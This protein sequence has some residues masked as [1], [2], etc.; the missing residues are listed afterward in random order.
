VRRVLADDGV[1]WLNLGDSYARNP[2]KGGSGTPNGR[3]VLS[4]GCAGGA[5]IPAESKEKDL[6][7]IPWRVAFALQADGW[8]LRADIIWHKPNPM[9]ESVRDRPTKAHEYVFL[10]TKS[11]RYYYDAAAIAEPVTDAERPQRSRALEIAQ[12]AG[13][14][15]A[16]FDAIRS[17]GMTD[18]GKSQVTQSGYG[19]NSPEVQALADEAKAALGGYYREF[20]TKRSGNKERTYGT[21]AATRNVRSVWP[22]TTKPYV[23]AH[24]A[25]MP[26][27]LAERCILAGSRPGDTVLDP[28]SGSGTTAS[29]AVGHGRQAI[30]IEA[31]PAYQALA[32]ERIGPMLATVEVAA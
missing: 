31:N 7:G 32:V 6:L 8:Y 18:A 24:F 23:G 21:N 25:T 1:L 15:E 22:I 2:A 12:A 11:A 9:P 17:C 19:A 29:V 20:L 4:T 28:F 14:T 16:H 30:G 10:L 5:G 13:L 3:N 27:D 26:P